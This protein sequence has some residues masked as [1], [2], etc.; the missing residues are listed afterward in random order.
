MR[1]VTTRTMR[2]VTKRLGSLNIDIP[3]LRPGT[4]GAYAL[5]FV[6]AGVALAL[7]FA[8]GP[9]VVGLQLV[10]FF[11]AVIITALISGFGAGFFCIALCA[12]EA[13]FFVFQPPFSFYIER[14]A[15]VLEL[16]LFIS[17][18]LFMV[19]VIASRKRAEQDVLASK[20]RLQFALDAALLGLW[21]Y[22]PRRC[23]SAGDTRFK[24]IFD[25]AVD[26][27]PIEEMK[28]LVHPDDAER[29]W[30]DRQASLDPANPNRSAHQYRI[31]RR[32]G[33]V[34]WV[35]VHWLGHCGLSQGERGA[36]DIIDIGVVQ[37][38]T[39]RKNAEE[40]QGRLAAI[41]TSSADA[42][43]GKTLDGIVTTW[44]EA[45]EHLF[46]YSA[47]EMIGQSIRRLIPA[48]RQA[49]EDMILARLARS[50]SIVHY[51]TVRLAKDGRTFNAS[52]TISPVQDAEGRVIG[53]A[54]IIRDISERK[55]AEKVL[56]ATKERLQ[57][58]LDAA[59]LGWG[60][61]DPIRGIA[62]W[63]TRLKEMF[64]IAED[65]TAIEE[66]TKRVHPDDVERVWAAIKAA[67]D[68]TDPKPYAIE[69]RHLRADGEVRWAEAHGLTHFEGAPPERRAVM[70]VGTA[71][72]V[73]E[74]KRH[75]A[76]REEREERE[77]LLMGEVIHRAKNMLSVV[78]AIARQT[79]AGEPEHFVSR[80]S[81]R[82]QALS[83]NQ[84][85]LVR[86]EWHGVE[87]EDLVRAQLSPFADLLGSR[88]ALCGP[89]LRLNA[90]SAQAIG[91]ALHE[92]CTN[93][94][95]YGA[96]STDTG[97]VDVSWI[98]AD[99]TF[100]MSWMERQG[101]L[102]STPKRRGFGS[103]VMA[104]MTER[105]VGGKVDLDY[106]PSGVTWHLTCPAANAVAR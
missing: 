96:L 79:A 61:Y 95:K 57:F 12:V 19:I 33:E 56:Q 3:A 53:A 89:Q 41:V 17:L 81:E 105:A 32:D 58:A 62:W 29:F 63:D 10:T 68:P 44:N 16:L 11:P 90:A 54:K 48:D 34:R 104:T 70:L 97:R 46:G 8:I 47:G 31:Q 22:D 106:A 71:Q 4:V 9:Y 18:S 100:T 2:E 91:L 21:R 87:I 27:M 43:V 73:T 7:R 26:E 82:I 23:V 35:E 88:I 86:N 59:R 93:A 45:A 78:D 40:A 94:G 72:D 103:T 75:E 5:A 80:F 99:D 42:I 74:R 50:E 85:L 64:E 15:D 39:E 25:V 30:A 28:K 76:E 6:S 83:A 84:D 101:P 98:V 102:V 1:E 92:L 51:E 37:D 55:Q 65:K 67:L 13:A 77:H 66:F 14:R 36:T 60:R 52:V 69:F 49:E 24:E 20:D 38:I